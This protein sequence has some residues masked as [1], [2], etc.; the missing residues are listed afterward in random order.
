[1]LSRQK[2]RKIERQLIKLIAMPQKQ[3]QPK[4]PPI[5]GAVC[6]QV[7]PVPLRISNKHERSRQVGRGDSL[8]ALNL[9][10]AGARIPAFC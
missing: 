3:F 4:A 1:V 9:P 5:R 10:A 6:A 2:K 7:L 8:D